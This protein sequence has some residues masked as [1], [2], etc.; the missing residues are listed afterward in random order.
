M[1]SYEKLVHL[2]AS[3]R[4]RRFHG[5][6]WVSTPQTVFHH[7]ASV[8]LILIEF[9][10]VD[11][12]SALLRAALQHDL[13]ERHTGD[14]P[15]PVKWFLGTSARTEIH[16]LE[17]AIREHYDIVFP[18]LTDRE[19]NLLRAAD[20]LDAVFSCL[21]QRLMGNTLLD[22]VFMAYSDYVVRSQ[23]TAVHSGMDH[24]WRQIQDAWC[25]QTSHSTHPTSHGMHPHR[26]RKTHFW[27]KQSSETIQAKGIVSDAVIGKAK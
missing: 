19:R 24:L 18:E 13:E 9:L 3:G 10:G 11:C 22:C 26:L 23:V 6:D 1:T 7:S 17:K 21:E 15:A 12:S 27:L 14:I 4:V 25:S 16:V 2:R 20:F 8:A 5:E